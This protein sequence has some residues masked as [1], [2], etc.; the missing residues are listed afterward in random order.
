M[1]LSAEAPLPAPSI[2]ATAGAV[3]QSERIDSIDVLRGFAVLGILVMNIQS[4]AMVFDAYM[5]PHVYGDLTGA[6]FSVWKISHVFADQ[7]FITIFSMLFGAGVVLMTSRQEA[8]AGRSAKVHYRRMGILLIFGLIHA[9]FIWYG[10]ILVSYALCGMIVYLFRRFRP[11]SLFI[12]GFVLIAV[13][14]GIFVAGDRYVQSLDTVEAEEFRQEFSATDAKIQKELKAYRGGWLD[15]LPHRASSAVMFQTV[16]F[17]FLCWRVTGLMLFGMAL[18]KLDVFSAARTP[19]TY[20]SMLVIGLLIGVPMI[21][22]GDQT[23]VESGWDPLYWFFAG[24]QFNYWASI[25]VSLAYISLVMLICQQPALKSITRPF[26]AVGQMAFTNYLMQS[27]ICT[28]IFYG[29]GFGYFGYVERVGQISIVVAIWVFQLIAS[30]IW[31]KYY[32]F[33]PAEWLWRALT[34]WKLPPMRLSGE[35]ILPQSV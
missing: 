34:Y 13:T 35:R 16:I 31:L 11:A 33:G 21:L 26:A 27:L 17:L 18:F 4:F 30:P 22:A 15:Q 24:S 3:P 23:I 20:A 9:Y 10:D 8:A 28:T 25:L 7:K 19:A 12:I 1:N 29:H 14:S 2:P 6:N 32:R 5:N